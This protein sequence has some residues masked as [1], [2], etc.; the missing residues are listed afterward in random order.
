MKT[1][2]QQAPLLLSRGA[3]LMILSTL[4]IIWAASNADISAC[5]LTLKHSV[6]PSFF[7]SP[8]VPLYMSIPALL[9]PLLI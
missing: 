1:T 5:S 6:T 4:R 2:T 7:M 3:H 8:T 9:W